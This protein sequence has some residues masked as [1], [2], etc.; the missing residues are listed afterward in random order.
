[1]RGQGRQAGFTLVEIMVAVAIV[2]VVLAISVPAMRTYT[3][4]QKLQSATSTIEG[5]LRRARSAAITKR[6]NV[7]FSVIDEANTYALVRDNE[8]DGNFSIML[9]NGT[10]DPTISMADLAFGGSD[11]V[12]FDPRGMPDNAGSVRLESRH[13]R[14]REVRVSPGSGTISVVTPVNEEN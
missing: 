6:C 5:S 2:G 4:Q 1:M 10:L 8:G 13:G 11:F 12:T 14:L 9:A 3:D 7:R